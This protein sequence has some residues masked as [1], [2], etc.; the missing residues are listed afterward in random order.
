MP[1]MDSPRVTTTFCHIAEVSRQL[2]VSP[3]HL[4]TLERDGRTPPPRPQRQGLHAIGYHPAKEHGRRLA[5]PQAEA[6]RGSVARRTM[7]DVPHIIYTQCADTTDETGLNALARVYRLILFESSARKQAAEQA[8]GPKPDGRD[9]TAVS[10]RKEGGSSVDRN[11]ET[12]ERS[13]QGTKQRSRN[14]E[15]DLRRDG[16]R[17]DGDGLV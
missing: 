7:S 6:S 4:R 9:K 15:A 1:D 10:K 3:E 11:K 13:C 14:A 16:L 8:P 12:K 5:S 2:G 17:A